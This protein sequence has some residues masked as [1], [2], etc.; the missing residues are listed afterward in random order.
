MDIK[1]AIANLAYRVLGDPDG[2]PPTEGAIVVTGRELAD[3]VNM[4]KSKRSWNRYR[5]MA[6]SGE[7][8]PLFKG[9]WPRVRE[10]D[11][12]ER[13]EKGAPT[14]YATAEGFLHGTYLLRMG[15]EV[16][17]IPPRANEDAS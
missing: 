4:T 17:L 7:T 15:D 13:A 5:L 9:D 8:V 6:V 3:F 16:T 2:P 1:L 10:V 12:L 11:Y 14:T